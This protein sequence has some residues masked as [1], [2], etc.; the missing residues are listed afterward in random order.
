M[1]L[2]CR[3][4]LSQ[5]IVQHRILISAVF[6][7][8]FT[9]SGPIQ[10]APASVGP[11]RAKDLAVVLPAGGSQRVAAED[12]IFPAAWWDQIHAAFAKTSVGDAVERESPL[13]NWRLVAMRLAP[14]Q[15]LLPYLSERNDVLC[16]PELRLVWQPVE[17]RYRRDRWVSY[18]DD[19]A[20]HVLYRFNGERELGVE[21]AKIWQDLLRR[22]E[23]LSI[24][25]NETYKKL[26]RT[27]VK[28]ITAELQDLRSVSPAEEYDG[29][30]ER[31][32]FGD[33]SSATRFTASLHSFLA[34][35]A[36]PE[37][38]TQLTAFSLPEG[39][40]PPMIDE[41]VFVAFEPTHSG[42]G[43][44]IQP[45]S[46]TVRSRRDGRILVEYGVKARASVRRDDEVLQ[47]LFDHATGENKSEL[48]E[49]VIWTFGDRKTK[50]ARIADPR[51]TH[52]AHTS[53]VSCHK[54]GKLTFDLHNLSYFEDRGVSISPR[55]EMD[56]KKELAW[57]AAD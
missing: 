41:W 48:D 9:Y 17:Q 21:R 49:A 54:L 42:Q 50:G 55:V 35:H 3:S 5:M 43:Q 36:R 40:E 25:E 31:P 27:L 39:R 38:L 47:D 4:C 45:Q 16:Q 29:V 19:R 7:V 2:A 14:C 1:L 6:S 37:L 46:L 51:Q 13:A 52:V 32:E 11:V 44:E 10:A 12:A 56:V 30:G 53:C 33:Q 15:P 24:T 34:K 22:A 18:A 23:S 20:V 57:I 28:S 26:T 8:A